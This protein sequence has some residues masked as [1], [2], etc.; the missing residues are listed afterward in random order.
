[1]FAVALAEAGLYNSLLL[2]YAE[3][4]YRFFTQSFVFANFYPKF[5]VCKTKLKLI[6]YKAMSNL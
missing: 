3:L 5:S 2:A 1:M 4:A 6:V